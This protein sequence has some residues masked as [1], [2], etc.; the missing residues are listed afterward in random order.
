MHGQERSQLELKNLG[1]L[2]EEAK[3]RK[4]AEYDFIVPANQYAVFYSEPLPTSNYR[5]QVF[6][7]S[8]DAV[9]DMFSIVEAYPT[10][11]EIENISAAP[12]P[13]QLL[14]GLAPKTQN[15]GPYTWAQAINISNV[16]GGVLISVPTGEIDTNNGIAIAFSVYME[17]QEHL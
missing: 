5:V 17:I 15:G 14:A 8:D 7:Y 9:V 3:A 11:S 1:A 2:I 12:E 4:A 13:C 16:G 10:L 6:T